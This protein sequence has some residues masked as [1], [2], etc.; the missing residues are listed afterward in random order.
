MAF[1][2][3]DALVPRAYLFGRLFFPSIVRDTAEMEAI[4]MQSN[5]DWAIVL[6]ICLRSAVAM[7]IGLG[8][9]VEQTP[10][11]SRPCFRLSR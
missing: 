3:R 2:L 6:R 7:L 5:L 11:V 8:V 9:P 10:A 4:L 1:L